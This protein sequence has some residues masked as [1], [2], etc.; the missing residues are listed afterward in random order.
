MNMRTFKKTYIEITNACNLDCDFCAGTKRKKEFMDAELFATVLNRIKGHSEYVYFHLMGEPLLHPQLSDFLDMCLPYA[1]KVN[2]TT[3]ASMPDKLAKLMDKPALRQVNM[4]LHSGKDR[5]YFTAAL[6]MAD[7][8]NKAGK[9]V[10]L[11]LWNIGTGIDNSEV[12]KMIKEKFSV[13]FDISNIPTHVRGIKIAE[14]VFLN[15]AEKF[16]WPSPGAPFVS[17][18]GFCYGLR[19]QIGILTDGT[20]VPCCLD[21]DGV[22]KLGNIKESTLEE[23]VTGTRAK[24]MYDAFS[25]RKVKE[26]LCKRCGYRERFK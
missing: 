1:Y 9:L 16:S 22:I 13:E 18:T 6:D 19:D 26:E 11:R 8:L 24:E 2:I 15:M 20:V 23:I 12:I 3:N 17:D 10:S 7:T 4:S 21:A 5:A 25:G 14:N